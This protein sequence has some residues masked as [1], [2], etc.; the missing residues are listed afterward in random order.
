MVCWLILIKGIQVLLVWEFFSPQ[1]SVV[2]IKAWT[3]KPLFLSLTYRIIVRIINIYRAH[4]KDSNLFMFISSNPCNS[5][6]GLIIIPKLLGLLGPSISSP[7]SQGWVLVMSWGTISTKQADDVTENSNT[8]KQYFCKLLGVVPH[9]I[10]ECVALMRW[11]IH[12]AQKYSFKTEDYVL[13]IKYS[14]AVSTKLL[15]SIQD[16]H[17]PK[18]E[19]SWN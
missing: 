8:T 15:P 5:L 11:T 7:Q 9:G 19:I 2:V 13:H 4:F 6:V 10:C 18:V 16:C 14:W 1:H 3:G 17:S 12:H